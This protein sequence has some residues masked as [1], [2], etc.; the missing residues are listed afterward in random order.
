VAEI[1]EVGLVDKI[2]AEQ[3]GSLVEFEVHMFAIF[4]VD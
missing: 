3:V 4:V 2:G 1:F